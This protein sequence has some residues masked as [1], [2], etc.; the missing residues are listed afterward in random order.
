MCQATRRQPWTRRHEVKKSG[1]VFL[2]HVHHH[3]HQVPEEGIPLCELAARSQASQQGRLLPV[4]AVLAAEHLPQLCRS[5]GSQARHWDGLAQTLPESLDLLR[6]SCLEP[7]AGGLLDEAADILDGHGQ[8]IAAHAERRPAEAGLQEAHTHKGGVLVEGQGLCGFCLGQKSVP[9]VRPLGLLLSPSCDPELIFDLAA[10]L[11]CSQLSDEGG[12]RPQ[13]LACATRAGPGEVLGLQR[14]AQDQR[15]EFLGQWQ[16]NDEP[17][18]EGLTDEPTQEEEAPH[19]SLPLRPR[20]QWPN[21]ETAAAQQEL[22][23]RIAIV[24]HP[25]RY[26]VVRLPILESQAHLHV[27]RLRHCVPKACLTIELHLQEMP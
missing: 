4:D 19:S 18:P 5:E 6:D 27:E 2:V 22:R 13:E 10:L 7:E 1:P 3:G 16:G 24:L 14:L 26:E 12:E 23:A 21:Q 17:F 8:R 15:E 11:A 9:K 20:W 25:K